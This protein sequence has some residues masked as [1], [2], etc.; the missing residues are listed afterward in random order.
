MIEVKGK[1][2]T[3]ICYAEGLED[4]A[5]R[6]IR[7]LCDREEFSGSRIRIMPDVHAG[8]GC[9]IG[10]TMTISD[11]VVPGMVGV[12]I[13]CGMETVRLGERSIDFLALD[14]LIRREIPSGREV[15]REPHPLSAELDLGRLRCAGRVDL[16]RARLS[17][18]T[19]GGGNHFIEIDRSGDGDLFLTV[20]SG[21]RHL[22]KEVA[23]LYQGL[24][25]RSLLEEAKKR[26]GEAAARLRAEGR[27][28][29]ID[30][31]VKRMIREARDQA[32][33]RDLSYLSGPLLE[34]Y[35]HDMGIVQRLA[36]LNRQAMA[37]VILDGLGLSEADRFSTI[38]NYIDIDRMI[39]RKGAVSAKDGERLL[40]PINMRDGSLICLG[41]G[42][43]DWN[44]S[45]PHGAGR[46]MS[47][48]A[49][50]ARLS[51]QEYVREMSGVYSSSVGQATL[52]ESPMA[53]KSL[54]EILAQLGPTAEVVQRILPVYNFKA[55][56]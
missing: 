55:S 33:P 12:D 28:T 46:T 13:G 36:A 18:G 41:R 17:L 30:Q 21:S 49:A 9:V 40:I 4:S 25:A 8:M 20:H 16:V 47:R 35:I 31:T 38:H 1:H 15:R 44:Q 27:T 42:N 37:Q 24:A 52:D 56:E 10:T 34:D 48:K 45:A 23:E 53:Y 39:L 19:L 3:A 2:N 29:D 7:A 54:S 11:K 6:Q 14:D 50:R 22:G 32:V 43:D 51:L 5:Q 26:V